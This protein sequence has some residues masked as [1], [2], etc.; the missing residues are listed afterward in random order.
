MVHEF[1]KQEHYSN[2]KIE[3]GKNIIKGLGGLKDENKEIE[4]LLWGIH[5]RCEPLF[6]K[7]ESDRHFKHI[8]R[9]FS[10]NIKT[11]YRDSHRRY[12]DDNHFKKGVKWGPCEACNKKRKLVQAHIIKKAVFKRPYNQWF[13]L[14]FHPANILFLCYDCHEKFDGRYKNNS[15]QTIPLSKSQLS[16]V[17]RN[18]RKRLKKVKKALKADKRYLRDYE[19][20]IDQFYDNMRRL[21]WTLLKSLR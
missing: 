8:R 15:G 14:K 19:R 7:S 16:R 9:K 4:S 5:K 20:K 12:P 1:P 2:D 13:F 3:I 10:E 21:L 18:L 6:R 17:K 11:L